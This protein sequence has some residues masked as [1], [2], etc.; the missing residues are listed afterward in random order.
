MK[1]PVDRF[2]RLAGIVAAKSARGGDCREQSFSLIARI[3]KNRVQAHPPCA[4]RPF[5]AGTMSA[6]P[7]ELVP[8][9]TT[10]GGAEQCRV[11]DTGVNSIGIVERWL[12][13]PDPFEFPRARR[14]VVELVR[15]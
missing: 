12:E 15:G 1:T 7:G 6:Q 4:R 11:F 9:L 2:P 14:A 8:C 3:Q 10:V 13:M 5:V